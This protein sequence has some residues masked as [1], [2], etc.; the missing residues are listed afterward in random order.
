MVNI[1]GIFRGSIFV[2]TQRCG[3][4][5]HISASICVGDSVSRKGRIVGREKAAYEQ[6]VSTS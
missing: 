2:V 4:N 1:I 5:F 3:A 6:I